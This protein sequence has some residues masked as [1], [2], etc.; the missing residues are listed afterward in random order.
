[1]KLV[2]ILRALEWVYY[3]VRRLPRWQSILAWTVINLVVCFV[4]WKYLPTPSEQAGRRDLLLFVDLGVLGELLVLVGHYFR[5]G[6]RNP[7]QEILRDVRASNPESFEREP[8]EGIE[9]H[10]V[11]LDPDGRKPAKD[12]ELSFATVLEGINRIEASLPVTRYSAAI[13]I[14]PMGLALATYLAQKKGI[15]RE[16]VGVILTT[17]RGPDRELRA[18]LPPTP[19]RG[20]SFH[21]T[22]LLLVDDEQKTGYTAKKA[23]ELLKNH[24]G[25]ERRNIWFISLVGTYV[26]KDE[27]EHC[28]NQLT[29]ENIL[30]QRCKPYGEIPH[31]CIPQRIAFFTPR[32]VKM[33]LELP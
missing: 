17:R 29:L 13:G 25:C 9:V 22:I 30:R 21:G 16:H 27:I 20:G 18:A 33:P 28:R 14:N 1:M 19:P 6:Q 7:V 23:F 12:V 4:A 24:F 26:G 5:G 11:G 2:D 15:P 8:D 32:A 31:D 3:R 10:V